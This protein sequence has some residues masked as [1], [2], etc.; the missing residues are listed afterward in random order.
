[1]KFI[2]KCEIEI[3]SLKKI[4]FSVFLILTFIINLFR[5]KV[6]YYSEKVVIIQKNIQK[7]IIRRKNKVAEIIKEWSKKKK[8]SQRMMTCPTIHLMKF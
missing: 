5:K 8:H 7:I 1:M 3:L 4:T 2:H 6:D